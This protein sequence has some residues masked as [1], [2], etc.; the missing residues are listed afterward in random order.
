MSL[1]EFENP[2]T[3]VLRL[4]ESRL[5]VIKDDGGLARIS[6]SQAHFDRELLKDYDAQITVSKTADSCLAQK[7]S[8]DG[9]LR[10]RI[11]SLRATITA[12]DKSIPG[13]DA[14]R[15]MRDKTLEQ[16]LLIIPE[17]RN[18]PYRTTYNFYPLDATSVSHKAY[19]AAAVSELAPSNA[20]W[21]E[22]AN[23]DYATLWSSDNLSFSKTTTGSNE[24][25]MVLLRFKVGAKVG[26]ARNEPRGQCLKRVVLLFEGYGLGPG[27]NGVAVK[28]WDH[29]AALWSE[30]AV[31][32]AGSDEALLHVLTSNLTDYVDSDGY[33]YLLAKTTSP[34]NGVTPASLSCDFAQ[35]TIDVRG[36][37]FC[38]IHSYK[39]VDVTD[40]KPF[41]YKEEIMLTAWLFE[42]VAV[43]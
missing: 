32:Y 15:L 10:R 27:G 5:R 17:N 43:S 19:S 9:K 31:G 18:L 29:V 36:I 28:V 24:F 16:I 20:G 37:T 13:A 40:V 1:A 30:V 26:E 38:D 11:Y 23:A 42:A 3:T 22:L 2:V 35:T 14:G 7:H 25:A 8:L 4:I 21:V 41:L 12:I 33:L 6:C 39:D 34:S